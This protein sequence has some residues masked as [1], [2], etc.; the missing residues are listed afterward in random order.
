MSFSS[1]HEPRR[2]PIAEINVTPLVDVVLVLLIIF[3][4]TA[5]FLQ[6]GLDIQ[7]PKVSAQGLDMREGIVLTI[8][9]E[10]RVVMD[11]TTV[12]LADL[13][14]AL[15]RK[16]AASRPVF[17]KADQ[18]VPYGVVAQVIGKARAAGVTNLGLV[19]EPDE[20]PRR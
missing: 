2:S 3:M 18:R 17:L 19:T 11:K 5:P 6:G 9:P 20:T 1:G 12:K 7:L 13:G 15:E 10:G 14:R 16:G 4:V 8:D